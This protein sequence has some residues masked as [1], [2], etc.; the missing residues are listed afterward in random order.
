MSG[1]LERDS[2]CRMTEVAKV[3]FSRQSMVPECFEKCSE[4]RS[5]TS[6]QNDR[7]W[8]LD[9]VSRRVAAIHVFFLV[10]SAPEDCRTY[11]CQAVV[12]DLRKG[13][14]VKPSQRWCTNSW[15][16]RRS[17]GCRPWSFVP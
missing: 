14:E 6:L 2:D 5:R 1:T 3:L 13:P 16:H 15:A 12:V 8:K 9:A 17:G 11:P 4:S 10:S 7:F